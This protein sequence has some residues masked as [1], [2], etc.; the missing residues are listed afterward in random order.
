MHLNKA[1]M[2]GLDYVYNFFCGG[3]FIPF[4]VYLLYMYNQRSYIL[5]YKYINR[6]RFPRNSRLMALQE[7]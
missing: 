2:N 4:I 5:D 1:L 7:F 6:V 3:G